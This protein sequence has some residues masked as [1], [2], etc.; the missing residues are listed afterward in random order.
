MVRSLYRSDAHSCIDV[1]F[2]C[3]SLLVCGGAQASMIGGGGRMRRKPIAGK[4]ACSMVGID[5]GSNNSIACM[6]FGMVE[7][8]WPTGDTFVD[9]WW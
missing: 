5:L 2:V 9:V 6:R 8:G 4:T 7:T 3:T 1:L